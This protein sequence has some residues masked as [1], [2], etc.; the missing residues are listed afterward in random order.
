MYYALCIVILI[1]IISINYEEKCKFKKY[2]IG[3]YFFKLNS[4]DVVISSVDKWRDF[5]ALD[6]SVHPDLD[7]HESFR[8]IIKVFE[9]A[10]KKSLRQRVEFRSGINLSSAVNLNDIVKIGL[11]QNS[12]TLI[13]SP[14][15]DQDKYYII[16]NANDMPAQFCETYVNLLTDL[17][18]SYR[19]K[20]MYLPY[21]TQIHAVVLRK[22]SEAVSSDGVE[23]N[24][25][26]PLQ[27]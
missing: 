18:I 7:G 10:S 19:F 1:F 27:N 4:C 9:R 8:V 17:E 2:S 13:A 24:N 26:M 3:R 5:V 11:P 16:C 15:T 20:I 12:K 14:L 23:W 25:K 6:I 22:L 21:I